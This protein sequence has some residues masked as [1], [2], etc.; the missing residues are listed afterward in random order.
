MLPAL[1]ALLSSP[2]VPPQPWALGFAAPPR[3]PFAGDVDG[4]GM[5]DLIVVFPEG[6]TILDVNL[7]VEGAKSGGGIQALPK[8][9]GPCAAAAVGEF[10]AAKGT[11]VAGLFGRRLRFAGDFRDG[12]FRT[13]A[14]GPLLPKSLPKPVLATV[15]RDLLVFSSTSGEGYRV[16]SSSMTLSEVRVPKG[17]VWMGDAGSFLAA[18][19]GRGE[20]LRLDP[21]TL[22]R[23]NKIGQAAKGSRPAA[24][25]GWIAFGDQVWTPG[26]VTPLP[27]SSLPVADT[28][29]AAGDFDGDGDADLMEFRYGKE[30]H[31]GKDVLLRRFVSPGESDSDHDGLTNDEETKLGTDP[32]VADTDHD[33]L[34]DGWEAKGV[35]GLDL[36]KLGADPRHADAVCLVSRFEA[37]DPARYAAEFAR[38]K[39]FYAELKTPNPDGKPGLNF[40]KVDLDPVKGDDTKAGWQTNRAKFRPEKWRGIVHWMQV[41]PGGG[42]Q[43]DELGDGGTCGEGALWAVF[44]HEFGHQL[45][46]NH[47]GFWANGSCPIYSSMMN[48]N[49][50][51]GFE[52]D[53][54]KIH[55]SDGAFAGY[56]LREDDLD[57]TIPLPYERVKF[58]S[59]GPY[60]YRLKPGADGKTTLIDWNWNGVFGEKHVRAD[61][62]YAYSTNAGLRDAVDKTSV[63][64]WLFV[65]KGAAYILYGNTDAPRV[66]GGDPTLTP[67]RPGKLILRRLK[68]P[69]KWEEPWTVAEDL[70]GDPVA[71]S[72]GDRIVVAAPSKGG[73]TIALLEPKK[74]QVVDMRPIADSVGLVPTLGESRGTPM[75]MLWD[76]R[77]GRI[78]VASLSGGKVGPLRTLPVT[79]VNPP[80]MCTDA[81]TGETIVA[82]AQNQDEARPHRWQIRRYDKAWKE[83]GM[84]WVEGPEGQ[85]RGTGR[86]TVLFDGGR[87]AGPQG[88]VFIYGKG[89]TDDKTPWACTY[90]ATTL[91]DKT[92]RGG[93]LVK[94]YYDEWTQSRSAPAAAWFGK[95]VIWAY[96]WVGGDG[97]SDDNLQVGYRALGIQ[98]EPFGDHDDVTF[99]RTF[100]LQHSLLSLG[101]G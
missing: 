82:L 48:Y 61:I 96:R 95:D 29:R 5:A 24:G 75:L 93:W 62:N 35:R 55:Y 3:L 34:L 15:G 46:L 8:W 25:T 23:L 87:D 13:L 53:R 67:S 27:P 77:D 19:N 94:R 72:V 31:T 98:S 99:I 37:V 69:F 74:R 83:T 9:A 32:L 39:R 26:G 40:I 33:G 80:G 60:R 64:P 1:V 42:G 78:R 43:A 85:A 101:K 91:A 41:T 90:V 30:A 7:T 52:D 79:S 28:V 38:V 56:T 76:P 70:V 10:D 18:Q 36:P 22:R 4:D 47:E 66:A 73:T 20:V 51:Y 44:T 71:T 21:T 14:D 97:P 86:L 49:Y 92:V 17:L 59:M 54:E 100:G 11:D 57:E 2:F 68:A 45:G 6:D 65:H 12:R 50:S 88:R 81:R 89:M 16:G 63:A 58:L 84:D